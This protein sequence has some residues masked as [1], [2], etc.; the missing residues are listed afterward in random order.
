MIDH[1]S[2]KIERIKERPARLQNSWQ[3][4]GRRA[5][6]VLRAENLAIGYRLPRREER[7]VASALQVEVEAGEMV[8]LLGPNGAGKS[9]LMRTLAGLQPALSG[10]VWLDGARLESLS[11]R[12]LARRLSIVLTDRVDVGNLS[13]FGLV[14]LGRHPYTS[15]SGGLSETDRAAV[16]SALDAVGAATLS[17]RPVLELS[18]GERQKVMI[19]RALAQ[20]PKLILLDEPTAFLDLPRRVEMMGVLRGLARETGRAVLLSTHDLDL[21]LRSADRLWLLGGDGLLHAGAPEDVI[22]SGAC[23]RAFASQR[24]NFDA[25]SGSFHIERPAAGIVHLYGEG[26]ALRWTERALEREGYCVDGER[27]G[28]PDAE[29]FVDP[30]AAR[31]RLRC[32]GAEDTFESIGA[33]VRGLGKE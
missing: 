12:E 30:D 24:V 20:E 18:D 32:Q 13:A 14:S 2:T 26:L 33:L 16:R 31:W 23:E 27:A 5:P 6:A 28:I 3:V 4:S 15:W 21:A 29:I 9:T 10:A 7:V 8:C 19:A 1:K 22:L 11:A 25:F 17:Q